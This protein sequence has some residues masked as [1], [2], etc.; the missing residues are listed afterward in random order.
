MVNKSRADP[1]AQHLWLPL[2][3]NQENCQQPYGEDRWPLFNQDCTKNGELNHLGRRLW[4][5]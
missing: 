1:N 5:K 3:L 4:R 2:T